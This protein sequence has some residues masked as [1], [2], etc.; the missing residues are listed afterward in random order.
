MGQSST[1]PSARAA[2][3]VGISIDMMRKTM[4]RVADQFG[5]DLANQLIGRLQRPESM[6]SA[7]FS[8]PP[9]GAGGVSVGAGPTTADVNMGTDAMRSTMVGT[10]APG[11]RSTMVGTEAPGLRSTMVGTDAPGLRSTMVGTDPLGTRSIMVGTDPFGTRSVMVGT[12]TQ[13]RDEDDVEMA[14][15]GGRPPPAPPGAGQRVRPQPGYSASSTFFDVRTEIV[16]H[17]RCGL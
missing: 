2:A 3:N 6:T 7:V 15:T 5:E 17:L 9:P 1:P 12:D 13:M 14:T 8:P 11:M 4:E 10:D 16:S